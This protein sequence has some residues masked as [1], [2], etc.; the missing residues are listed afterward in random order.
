M[1]REIIAISRE[2]PNRLTAKALDRIPAWNLFS[3]YRSRLKLLLVQKIFYFIFKLRNRLK[4]INRHHVKDLMQRDDP[5][6]VVAN[7]S[8]SMDVIMHQAVHAHL[9]N[10]V[11]SFIDSFAF[12]NFTFPVLS[13]L[14]YFAEQ[15]PR[16]GP[17]QKSVDRMVNRLIEGDNVLLFP[18]GTFNFGLVTQGFTGAARVAHGYFKKTGKMLQILP[19]CTIGMHEAYNPHHRHRRK[20]KKK[21]KQKRTR[22]RKRKK[23]HPLPPWVMVSRKNQ[24]VKLKFGEPFT[25]SL[26]DEP[27]KA[28]LKA[29]TAKIMSRIASLWGQ[30][31]VRSNRK[32]QYIAKW[33]KMEGNKRI[34]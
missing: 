15:I 14:L 28:D 32:K 31:K 2:N 21:K 16:Q 10:L 24:Q 8:G 3:A 20:L 23:M 30:K 17:G 13:T 7:H 25:V 18:E 6:L 11:Y 12:H 4:I 33:Y 1:L 34:Y 27:V 9:N 29:A 26:P 5:F 19:S 22:K